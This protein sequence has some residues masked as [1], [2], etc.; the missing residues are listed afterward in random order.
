MNMTV[1]SLGVNPMVVARVAG[2]EVDHRDDPIVV[3]QEG[4]SSLNSS[5]YRRMCAAFAELTEADGEVA[6]PRRQRLGRAALPEEDE[7]RDDRDRVVDRD[8]DRDQ[9]R[10]RELLGVG[11][12]LMF[13][14]NPSCR[15]RN[16]ATRPLE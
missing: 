15:Q 11:F 10:P 3:D 5:L 16:N 4:A 6:L 13:S 12:G 8:H 9:P 14:A 2:G 1:I 7:R